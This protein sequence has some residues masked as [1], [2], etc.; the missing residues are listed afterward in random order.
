MTAPLI[1]VIVP[2][3]NSPDRLAECLTALGAQ[4]YPLD[5]FEVLVVD[6]G[7]TDTTAEVASSFPFVTLLREP[8]AGSYNARNR[9]LSVAAGEWVAFTDADCLPAADWLERGAEAAGVHAGAGVLAG[10]VDVFR[11]DEEASDAC[12]KFEQMFSFRQSSNVHKGLC[13]TANWMSPRRILSD[14]GGFDGALKSGGDGD[15]ARRVAAAGHPL[16]YVDDMA[17][18]HPARGSLGALLGK[19]RRVVGGAWARLRGP[20]RSLRVLKSTLG[21]GARKVLELIRERELGGLDRLKLAGIVALS[22][23]VEV[24]EL[25]RLSVGGQPARA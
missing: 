1:S 5:R 24:G 12:A 17:V 14:L 23:A 9:G 25:L 7:S 8:V 11:A 18:R 22:V 21:N 15:M 16:V 10:R 20:L 19:R 4:T 2:V 6:N 3:W 13:V